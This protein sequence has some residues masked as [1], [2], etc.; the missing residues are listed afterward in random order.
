MIG[1]AVDEADFAHLAGERAEERLEIAAVGVAGKAVHDDD[2]GPQRHHRVVDANLRPAFS[3]SPFVSV[4]LILQIVPY[5]LTGFDAVSKLAEEAHPDFNKANFGTAVMLTLV[6]GW[7][8]YSVVIAAVSLSVPWQSITTE[9]F[10]TATAFERALGST[11]VT[12]AVM[13]VALVALLKIFNANLLSASR[14]LYAMGRSGLIDGRLGHVDQRHQTPVTAIVVVGIAV[15]AS[16]FLGRSILVPISEVG[17]VAGALG[18]LAACAAYYK[19]SPTAGGRRVAALGAVVC[20][21]MVLMKVI[22][23]VPGSFTPFEWGALGAWCGLGL[24]V[25]RGRR[26]RA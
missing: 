11:T 10:A 24:L 13:V 17:S 19:L 7:I 21:L 16:I 4:V 25:R 6:V 5:F 8:F 2:F 1:F 15:A 9:K 14:L 20:L 18:W 3:H 26:V 12:Q 22:P 23:A